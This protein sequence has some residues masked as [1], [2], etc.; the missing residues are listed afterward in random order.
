MEHNSEKVTL[1]NLYAYLH[2]SSKEFNERMKEEAKKRDEE[3]QR[4]DEEAKKRDEEAKKRD[5]EAKKRAKEFELERA[6][7]DRQL[8]EAMQETDRKME[9]T[10]RQLKE[11]MQEHSRELKEDRKETERLLKKTIEKIYDV[12]RQLGGIGNSNGESSEEYFQIAFKKNPKLNGETYNEVDFNVKPRPMKGQEEDEY[13]IV[14][15]NGKSV[16]IIEVKY[17]VREENIKEVLNKP[18]TFRAFYPK[19]ENYKLYLGIASFS[20]KK[21]RE[22]SILKA[23][24]AV[25]KQVG[26]KVVINSE[27][28]KAF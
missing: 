6:E 8:K 25:I 12:S 16:A 10:D 23:G 22:K 26:D 11:T 18:K 24:I 28:L 13:D 1:E 17:S 7:T 3:Y 14:L 27:N 2:E 15:E 20:F 19:Y 4:R 9:K 21:V 5:E